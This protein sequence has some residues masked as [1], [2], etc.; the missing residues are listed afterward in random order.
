MPSHA[1][2]FAFAFVFVYAFDNDAV[3][4]CSRSKASDARLATGTESSTPAKDEG[5]RNG[6]ITSDW[7][8]DTSK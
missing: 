3:A 1:F 7:Q 8:G 5:S 4:P 6:R 2:V